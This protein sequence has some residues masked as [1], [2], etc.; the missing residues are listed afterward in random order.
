MATIVMVVEVI[1]LVG[2][3]GVLF[4]GS[5]LAKCNEEI[6]RTGDAGRKDQNYD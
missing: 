3:F 1:L 5:W 6:N 4:A 2:G